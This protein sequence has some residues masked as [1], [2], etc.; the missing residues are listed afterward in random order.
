MIL[1]LEGNLGVAAYGIVANLA[2]IVVAIFN[3]LSQGAQPLISR[4]YGLQKNDTVRKIYKMTL[5]TSAAIA[6]AIYTATFLFS[7]SIISVF[8]SEN[9]ADIAHMARSGLRIYFLGLFFAGIN[10]VISMFLS[11]TQNA[12]PAYIISVLRGLVVIIPMVVALSR[13]L[14]MAGVW[15]SCML[16]EVMVAIIAVY[17][18]SEGQ[19]SVFVL[20]AYKEKC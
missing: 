19:K 4:Y 8:N 20:P 5:V 11:A 14:G 17:L 10:I 15:L 7:D 16:T 6:I 3:G 9:N 13:F 1:S 2:F 18:A 12:K